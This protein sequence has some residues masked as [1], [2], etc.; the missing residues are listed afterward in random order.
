MHVID[1]DALLNS[2][3]LTDPDETGQRFHAKIVQKII[4]G[5]R[6]VIYIQIELSTW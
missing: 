1:P 6:N 4:E 2:T 5:T 3:Y